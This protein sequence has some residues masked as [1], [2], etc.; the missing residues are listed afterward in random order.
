MSNQKEI[1]FDINGVEN[2]LKTKICEWFTWLEIE[3]QV[4]KNTSIAYF[5]DLKIFILFISKHFGKKINIEDLNNLT[6]MDFRSYLAHRSSEG[7]SR[8]SL[9]RSVSTL[10][11]FFS[12]L[13]LININSNPAIK[14]LQTPK[15]PSSIPRSVPT[16][17]VLKVINEVKELYKDEWLAKRDTAILLLLYGCGLRISEALQLNGGDISPELIKNGILK[18]L[19]K[20]RKERLVPVLKKVSDS[21]YDYV[22]SCPFEI[23]EETPLFL[24]KR[25]NRLS[26]RIVQRLMKKIREL[27]DFES[28]ITPHSLRH[29]FATHILENGGDL[30]TI[31][32]L[33]GH[34]SL[35]TTQRY[36]FVNERT[37]KSTFEKAHPRAKKI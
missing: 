13:E 20:G 33:L 26:A 34:S 18:I 27:L 17:D 3:K 32:E 12:Y 25:G 16:K 7:L 5:R 6:Q 30:R 29:S 37:I 2:N 23:T 36:T 15:I 22:D 10:R 9:G 14:T 1:G 31:Q 4:S 19:G 24:G 35:S 8:N 11:N 28:T 21:I